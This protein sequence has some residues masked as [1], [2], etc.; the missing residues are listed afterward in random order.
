MSH[1][2]KIVDSILSLQQHIITLH[3]SCGDNELLKKLDDFM[4][5]LRTVGL[6]DD[7][8][9]NGKEGR[10][11]LIDAKSWLEASKK[12]GTKAVPS[13]IIW[14]ESEFFTFLGSLLESSNPKHK[15]QLIKL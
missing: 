10:Y 8:N 6:L 11:F 2:Q 14:E 7:I 4:S 13:F 3:Q 9:I 12:I 1:K 15:N 5:G